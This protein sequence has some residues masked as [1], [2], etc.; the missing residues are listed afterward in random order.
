MY[1]VWLPC[2]YFLLQ[3]TL[4]VYNCDYDPPPNC[5][6]DPCKPCPEN[7]M[8]MQLCYF[9]DTAECGMPAALNL[10]TFPCD[11]PGK[12]RNKKHQFHERWCK[13]HEN[14]LFGP[15]PICKSSHTR[16]RKKTNKVGKCPQGENTSKLRI[17]VMTGFYKETKNI[18]KETLPQRDAVPTGWWAQLNEGRNTG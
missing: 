9:L 17:D 10:L 16:S 6:C 8:E 12:V 3:G 1:Y 7:L 11:K 5:P 15:H 18:R 4:A 2:T 13:A 14:T